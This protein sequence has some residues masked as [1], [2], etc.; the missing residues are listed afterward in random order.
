MAPIRERSGAGRVTSYVVGVGLVGL[1]V[2]GGAV[3]G[4]SLAS[5][6]GPAA[7]L[8]PTRILASAVLGGALVIVPAEL[9]GAVGGFRPPEL[10][11]LGGLLVLLGWR[12]RPAPA[13]L[14]RG[15]AAVAAAPVVALIAA[16]WTSRIAAAARAGIYDVDSLRYHLPEAAGL[17]QS[18]WT[19]HLHFTELDLLSAFDPLNAEV[20]HAIGMAAFRSDVLSPVVNVGWIA[21]ALLAGWSLGAPGGR[22]A[23]FTGLLVAAVL[24]GT[25]LSA[26]TMPG[27]A[28]NDVAVLAL[29]VASVALLVNA[30]ASESPIPGVAAAGVAMG[31]AVGTKFAGVAPGLALTGLVAALAPRGRRTV[32]LT[33]WTAGAIPCGAFWYA[34]NALRVG[35]PVPSI[36]VPGLRSPTD[37]VFDARGFSIAHY[38]L[39][40]DFWRHVVPNG[41][42]LALGPGWPLMV[43]VG[44]AGVILPLGVARRDD[45]AL[46]RGLAL[47]ASACVIAYVVTPYSAGG[48]DG[49][50]WLFP[51]DIRFAFP[52]ALLAL[53]ALT[54]WVAPS[55]R[56][57]GALVVLLAVMLVVEQFGSFSVSQPA[58][59][60]GYRLPAVGV[61]AIVMA[62]AALWS[63]WPRTRPVLVVVSAVTALA[64]GAAYQRTNRTWY[65]TGALPT[66]VDRWAVSVRHARIGVIGAPLQYPLYGRGLTN[67]VNYLA[68]PGEAGELDPLVDCRALVAAMRRLRADFVVIGPDRIAPPGVPEVGWVESA[69][70]RTVLRDGATTVLA[71][72]RSPDESA[73]AAR[74]G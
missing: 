60:S 31:L 51:V 27:A 35:N 61:G 52:A 20:V 43:G 71:V 16:E 57:R 70:G 59:G 23:S 7:A 14:P 48:P 37:L 63:S 62:A 9:L 10:A 17:V 40:G 33:A 30:H 24:C 44:A 26:V 32:H 42:H 2:G 11:A 21:L 22:S 56:L 6:L 28:T 39:R 8:R 34:R 54:R 53:V 67:R 38:L 12:L 18:G 3:A 41:L 58:W 72:P 19:T 68:K 64:A 46:Q 50:P 73:C 25:P 4:S 13:D 69:G 1:L 74:P 66:A 45:V 5:R 65:A 49:D 15:R 36:H 55:R 47:A 29:L